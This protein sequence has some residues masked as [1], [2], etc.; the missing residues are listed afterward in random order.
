MN[1]PSFGERFRYWFDNWMAKGTLA[2]MA[3][4]G[5]ATVVLVLVV[6]GLVMLFTLLRA[7]PE[8]RPEDPTA[9]HPLG[10][11]HAHPRP[12]HHGRRHRVGVPHLHADHHHRRP[13]HRREPDRH[14]LRRVRQQ[15]RRAA[16][17]PL[18]RPRERP[19]RSSWAGARKVFPIINEI[20]RRQ[21]VARQDASSSSSPTA[22]RSRWRTTSRRRSRKTGKT[23]DH[24]ALRR[25]DEPRRP[26]DRQPARR[27]AASSCSAPE[28]ADDPDS[29]VIKTTLAVTNNP[30]R[31][32]EPY[33]IVGE[34]QDPANLEAARLVGHDEAH[35]VLGDDLISRIMVQ[36][37]RQ[38][39]LSVVYSE[40][41]DFDGDEIYFTEQPVARRQ[42]AT[43]TRSSPSRT[44][45]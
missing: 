34:L 23:Q 14:H 39:G 36:T 42:D 38:S 29:D 15:G 44:R 32:D 24:R 4:L 21:R 9:R 43:S 27:R 25:P 17:G 35:W 13:H 20:V 16:Q 41:L 31:K 11:P 45:W 8:R 37:C 5:I 30:K 10:Q 12:R 3:L 2:L 40:L 1:K 26:R 33:H 18:A 7:V 28:D 19:H 6:F 22:T